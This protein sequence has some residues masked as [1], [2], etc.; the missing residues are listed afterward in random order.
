MNT[1]WRRR[2]IAVA[3]LAIAAGLSA[4]MPRPPTGAPPGGGAPVEHTIDGTV[5]PGESRYPPA[6][7]SSVGYVQRGANQTVPRLKL[8]LESP[9]WAIPIA[10]DTVPNEF[11]SRNVTSMTIAVGAVEFFSDAS[12]EYHITYWC[13]SDKDQAW[14]VLG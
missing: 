6:D 3:V 9:L 7:C 11:L 1:R 12:R 2:S 5:P 4:C 8:V 10:H 14:T 13:T